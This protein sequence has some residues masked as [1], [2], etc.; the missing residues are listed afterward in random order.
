MV[1]VQHGGLAAFEQD[2]LAR[3]ERIVEHEGCVRHVRLKPFTKLEQLVGGAV[4]VN[5]AAVVQLDQHLV[6]LVQARLDFVV[7]M[8]LVE[9]VVHTNADA[10]DLVSVR[11][12]DAATGGAD[13][14]LAQEAFSHLVNSAMVGGDHVCGLADQQARA[15]HTA[16]FEAVDLLEQDFRI[17]YHAVADDRGHV[18]ADD[19]AGQQVQSVGFVADDHGMAR[20]VAAVEA[21][22]I[23]DMRAD[24]IGRLAFAFIAP[25]SADKNDSGHDAPPQNA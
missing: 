20:V 19:A 24:K 13:L 6:L 7:Q 2:G 11:R 4:D 16:G 23:V 18:R 5:R 1:H 21:G 15:V 8:L 14:V 22:D 3:V 9:Q 12:A 10:V 17:D 25:L